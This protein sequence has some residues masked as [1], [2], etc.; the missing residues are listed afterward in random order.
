MNPN[1]MNN[2]S[3]KQ[4]RTTPSLNQIYHLS[5]PKQEI[6]KVQSKKEEIFRNEKITEIYKNEFEDYFPNILLISKEEFLKEISIRIELIIKELFTEEEIKENSFKDYITESNKIINEKYQNNYNILS[7]SYENYLKRPKNFS[8]L[9]HFRKHCIHT[10]DYAYHSCEYENS[11][12]IEIKDEKK[13]M[14]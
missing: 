7:K 11:K 10:D 5:R 14:K 4:K 13:K 1:Y 2:R 9:K 12:L 3:L 6:I 8:Y